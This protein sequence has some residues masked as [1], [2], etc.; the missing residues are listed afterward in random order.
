MFFSIWVFFRLTFMEHRAAGEEIDSNSYLSLS[1]ASRAPSPAITSAS[2]PVHI[3]TDL[4]PL[5]A[6]LKSLITIL[7]FLFSYILGKKIITRFVTDS[8]YMRG[9][10]G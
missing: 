1:P 5:V 2:T 3:A 9:K 10:K 7:Q 6:E 4:K 8:E